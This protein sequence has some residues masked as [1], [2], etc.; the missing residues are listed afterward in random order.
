M[1]RSG[2]S[3]KKNAKKILIVSALAVVVAAYL[4]FDLGQYINL[5]YVKGYQERLW[6]LYG[7]H[8]FAVIAAYMIGYIFVTSLSLPG[9]AV[10]TLAGSALFG[11]FTGTIIVSFSST[12][13]AT[14]ACFVSRYLLRDWVQARF[15]DDHDYAPQT[16]NDLGERMK[17]AFEQAFSSG[18][19]KVVIIGSDCPD[20]P[21]EIIGEAFASLQENGAVIGPAKDGGQFLRGVEND[22]LSYASGNF[23]KNIRRGR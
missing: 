17:N 14:L 9:A 5:S 22:D 16:G 13:G 21:Q 6:V 23:R 12:I 20:L 4:F 15:G 10:M 1:S 7:E 11:L 18:F 2:G 8:G 3:G 19:S